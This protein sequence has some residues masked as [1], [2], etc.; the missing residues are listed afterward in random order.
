MTKGSHQI[1]HVTVLTASLACAM[2]WSS[3]M[4]AQTTQ[5]KAPVAPGA[6]LKTT[7][8]T[9]QSPLTATPA[10]QTNAV[11]NQATAL[12]G[13][14][15][16]VK[17]NLVQRANVVAGA[18]LS[19]TQKLAAAAA[20]L[21]EEQ[22]EAKEQQDKQSEATIAVLLKNLSVSNGATLTLASPKA[23]WG[24]AHL[25]LTKA[26]QVDFVS[27]NVRFVPSFSTQNNPLLGYPM[28]YCEFTAPE[29]GYY[30]A[31]FSIQAVQNKSGASVSFNKS[32]FSIGT[33]AKVA[34]KNG[35]NIVT[36]VEKFSK[37][38]F[39]F[40]AVTSEENFDFRSCEISRIK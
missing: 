6:T 17:K 32:A 18:S 31:A 35:D 15:V 19:A 23:S 22:K 30:L 10:V 12:T 24:N 39:A 27:G 3:T 16:T 8:L 36:L 9:A 40:A 37:G 5:L 11:T 28:A 2:G 4:W 13:T 33:S 26:Y 34:L 7:P 20:L 14:T 29:D 38:S 21:A 25:S 1:F